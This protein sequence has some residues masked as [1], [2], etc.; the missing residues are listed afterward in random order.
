MSV[1]T[2]ATAI[3]EIQRRIFRN[4]LEIFLKRDTEG[5]FGSFA[6][7][8]P[9]LRGLS[10]CDEFTGFRSLSGTIFGKGLF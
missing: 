1:S 9:R 6:I 2:N 3:P 5:A 4:S 8:V 10:V 7:S